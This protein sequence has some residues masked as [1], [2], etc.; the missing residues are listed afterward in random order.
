VRPAAPPLPLP[1]P[2]LAEYYR[3][4]E[5]YHVT[6]GS[7]YCKGP[8]L[9]VNLRAYDYSLDLWA[10]GCV[11]AAMIFQTDALFK[12]EDNDDQLVKIAQVLGTADLH[13]YLAK[14]NLVL[15]DTCQMGRYP[16]RSLA[17]FVTDKNRAHCGPQ[18]LDLLRRVLQYDHAQR[19]T[20]VE[21]LAHPYF[22]PLTRD[23]PPP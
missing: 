5:E 3:P 9:L 15:P 18:A 7:R 2:G 19:P 13:R 11:F 4:G 20:A 16:R 23:P 14:Y 12:G 22:Q 17:E 8:E 1:Y 6:V 10:F 21:A